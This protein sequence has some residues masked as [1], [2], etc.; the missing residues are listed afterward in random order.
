MSN[1]NTDDID[2]KNPVTSFL[3][4]LAPAPSTNETTVLGESMGTIVPSCIDE[5]DVEYW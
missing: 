4:T 3:V 2:M 1:N 5:H